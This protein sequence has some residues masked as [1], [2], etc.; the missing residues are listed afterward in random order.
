[1]ARRGRPARVEGF[2]KGRPL[3][4]GV[5]VPIYS[6]MGGLLAKAAVTPPSEARRVVEELLASQEALGS[7]GPDDVAGYLREA[8]EALFSLEEELV[9]T[10]A[11]DAGMTKREA[12]EEVSRAAEIL[13][14]PWL[15]VRGYYRVPVGAGFEAG[16]RRIPG[17]GLV[18][19]P[20]TAPLSAPAAALSYLLLN[21]IPAVVKPSM[22][23]PLATVELV[24][25]V[26]S[27]GLAAHVA[28][29]LGAGGGLGSLLAS[30]ERVSLIVAYMS[31]ITASSIWRQAWGKRVLA[32]TM[33]RTAAIVL[34]GADPAE[35]ARS[36]V[37]SRFRHAGQACCSTAWVIV[38][39]SIHD[40]L[41]DIIEDEAEKLRAGDPLKP[42]IDIGPLVGRYLVEKAERMVR[43][44]R[45]RGARVV[46]WGSP[47]R[48]LYPPTLIDKTPK[49]AEVLD[50]DVQA[51]ILAVVV[52]ENSREAISVANSLARA[53]AV[54]VYTYSLKEVDDALSR[55]DKEI[56]LV[57]P[58]EDE[59][60]RGILCTS[61]ANLPWDPMSLYSMPLVGLTIR[62]K[63]RPPP[64][65][66]PY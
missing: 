12:S 28:L 56:V 44:A 3:G 53:S 24:R 50:L 46:Q 58:M 14:D 10:L 30:D 55:L 26:T 66:E 7:M 54:E 33:G 19:A 13:E 27:T 20:Y 35:A 1:M 21:G 40:A 60:V 57:N 31:S 47:T 61:P 25:A 42:G 4:G 18:I 22:K 63:V 11:E 16:I 9:E 2:Y 49:S 36:I 15:V 64:P 5:E 29:V 34:P 48:F 43:D 23:A 51:P 45:A 59:E 52:V 17:V 8:A 32:N 37:R 39:R 65:E 6:P 38:E 41:V 62:S